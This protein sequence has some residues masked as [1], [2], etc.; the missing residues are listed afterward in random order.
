[1]KIKKQVEQKSVS[2]KENLKLQDYKNYLEASQIERK[3]CYLMKKKIDVDS[4]I[5]DLKEFVGNN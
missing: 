5:K 4:F 1:M 3:I 2:F